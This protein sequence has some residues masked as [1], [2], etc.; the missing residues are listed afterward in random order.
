MV[1]VDISYQGGLRCSAVHGPSGT[2]IETDAPVD[3]NGRGEAFSPTDLTATSLGSCMMT[4]MGIV[5]QRKGIAMEGATVQVRKI[6][7][8]DTPRRIG[9]LELDFRV[10]LPADHPER[11]LLEAAALGCPVHHSLHPD[12]E[13]IIDWQWVG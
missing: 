1:K 13:V 3:N 11:A 6:M 12:I 2:R 8:T 7:A 9:R 4:I 5:A 10:P